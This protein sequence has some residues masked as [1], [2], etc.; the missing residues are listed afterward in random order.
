[1]D[2]KKGDIVRFKADDDLAI[3]LGKAP[4]VAGLERIKVVWITGSLANLDGSLQIANF[5]LVVAKA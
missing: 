5:D 2:F 1:M 3:V 4:S